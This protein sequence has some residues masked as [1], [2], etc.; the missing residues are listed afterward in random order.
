MSSYPAPNILTYKSAAAL[1]KGK[2]VKPGADKEHAVVAS[3]ATDKAIGICQ[4]VSEAAEDP[5]EVAFPGGGGLALLGGSVSAGDYLASDANGALVATTT[6]NDNVIA[7]ALQ[8][9]VEN[10]LIAVVV[11]N[12]NY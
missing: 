11:L 10:D 8:D 2:V 7:Q 3:A 1:A 6:A 12:F 9:G 4:S 5:I